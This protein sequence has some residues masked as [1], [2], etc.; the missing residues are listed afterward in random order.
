M[1]QLS[2]YDVIECIYQSD[3]TCVYRALR[4]ADQQPV[5]LKQ[6]REKYPSSLE[7]SRFQHAYQLA[8]QLGLKAVIYAEALITLD[9]QWIMILEDIGG[10]SL[11]EHINKNL[12]SLSENLTLALQLTEAIATL[13]EA[14]VIHKN[15]NSQN[16][17][18][19]RDT[20]IIKLTDLAIASL[21]P[22]EAPSL[23]NSQSLEGTLAYLSPEQTGRINLSLDY[24]TDFYSLGVTLFELFTGQLP[25]N[26]QDPLELIHSHIARQ[27]PN[28]CYVNAQLPSTIGAIIIKLLAK[29]PDHRY[30]STWGLHADL[31]RCQQEWQKQ[32]YINEFKLGKK[33]ISDKFKL[34]NKLYERQWA[35]N[36]IL[37]AIDR[38]Q[39]HERNELILITGYEGIGKTS[40]VKTVFNQVIGLKSGFYISGRFDSFHHSIPYY[41]LIDAVKE[42]VQQ[43]LTLNDQ[44][45]TQL[46]QRLLAALGKNISVILNLVPE[47]TLILGELSDNETAPDL[48]GQEAFNRFQWV[49]IKTLQVFAQAEQPLILFLDDLQLADSASLS[50]LTALLTQ[51]NYLLVITAYRDYEIT[52]PQSLT[53]TLTALRESSITINTI[54]LQPLSKNQVC[55]YIADILHCNPHQVDELA[56]LILNKTYGNPFFIAQFLKSLHAEK[57]ITFDPI[58]RHWEW[59]IERIY[60]Q[61]MT[62]NVVALL[63]QDIQKLDQETQFILQLSACIGYQFELTILADVSQLSIKEIA[64]L[65]AEPISRQLILPLEFNHLSSLDGIHS[66]SLEGSLTHLYRFSHERIQQAAYHLL[67]IHQRREIHQKIG[68]LWLQQTPQPEQSPR[69]FDIVN[70]LNAGELKNYSQDYLDQLARFNLAAGRRA[71]MSAAYESASR[72]LNL[73]LGLLGSQAWQ[74]CYS[75]VLELHIV[76]AETFCLRGDFANTIELTETILKHTDCLLDQVRAYEVKIQMYKAQN[77]LQQAVNLGL[78][79]LAKLGIRFKKNPRKLSQLFEIALTR[80]ALMG[81]PI[82]ELAHLPPMLDLEK[83]AAMRLLLSISPPI[84]AVSPNLLPLITCK[85]VRL[86]IAYGNAPES[87]PAYAS[88]GYLLCEQ[89]QVES[90]YR[91]GQLALKLQAQQPYAIL[92]S[93]VL[94]I[95]YGVIAHYKQSLHDTLLPLKEA[96]Q[97]GLD[98]GNFEYAMVSSSTWMMHAFFAGYELNQLEQEIKS[99]INLQIQLKQH[100][101]L[102]VNRL[103]LQTVSNLLNRENHT[104]EALIHLEGQYYQ[105]K[106]LLIEHEKAGARGLIFQ[107]YLQ[108]LVLSCF[109]HHKGEALNNAAQAET[110][111]N[112]V[113]G[114]VLIPTFYFYD[115]LSQL[116][117]A[118]TLSPKEQKPYLAKVIKNQKKLLPYS[119]QAPMNY[120]HKYTLIRALYAQSAGEYATAREYYDQA[121]QQALAHEFIHEAALAQ[122]LAGQFYLQRQ[123]FRLAQHYLSDAFQ[124]YNRWGAYAKLKQIETH[125]GRFL[126]NCLSFHSVN[127]LDGTLQNSTADLELASVLKAAQVFSSEIVLERLLTKMMLITLE[128]A[129]AQRGFL[130]LNRHG[131]WCV[132]A[133]TDSEQNQVKILP[134]LPLKDYPFLAAGIVYYVARTR[135]TLVLNDAA[136][137]PR[138]ANDPYL[139]EKKPK[140]VLCTPLLNQGK[141]TGLLYLENNL[142]M[143]IFTPNRL[144]LLNLLS[145][146]MAIAIDNARLYAELEEKVLERT[147]ALDIKNQQ[148][149]DLNQE[150]NEFLAIVAHDLKNPLSGI[151]GLVEAIELEFDQLK[152]EEILEM[153]ATVQHSAQQMFELINNLLNVHRIESGNMTFDFKIFNLLP[154]A[155]HLIRT[156]E[157]RANHKSIT[158]RLLANESGYPVY[159]DEK[160]VYQILDNLLSNAIKYSPYHTQVTLY[161]QSQADYLKCVIEDQGQGFTAADKQQLFGKFTRLSAQPTGEESATG[162]GLFIVKK[163]VHLLN[164]TVECESELGKGARFIV[165]LP[166]LSCVQR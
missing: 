92:K 107:V 150:K 61:D 149:M 74:R 33:D 120:Q 158:L 48:T 157:A 121:I 154:L 153:L 130:L 141:L 17:I 9:A 16:I 23:K 49:W 86:S 18:Y 60:A 143:G 125:Y 28:P 134:A 159:A 54:S 87:I 165:L 95:V 20:G 113:I 12:F 13:H 166:S 126:K 122:E 27:A 43:L 100:T 51:V 26:H 140:S 15:I 5:I 6:L 142:A 50:L 37:K 67:P 73:G 45:L 152:K 40:L 147:E 124:H 72:Y 55:Q 31:L 84:Y 103:Y 79:V 39:H 85:R 77:N 160:I 96:Q 58:Q 70:Q 139:L 89:Q 68:E 161:L 135:Q 4:H 63:T 44:Q 52:A 162:L 110:H 78:S 83:Q 24:R 65:L 80:L 164:G 1:L 59:D 93:R 21:L 41:G 47:L 19:N 108:K 34:P 123:L 30:Q 148:L 111:L 101:H 69:L 38:I 98:T 57:L 109:L 88:Y 119:Q 46:R 22:R 2:G 102:H 56:E 64:K 136:N 97:S 75:L 144:T 131:Q 3:K 129:G 11:K 29:S 127:S 99:E 163:L 151:Q 105:E 36:M 81:R 62:D 106:Q 14:N 156:Y 32:R 133:E 146:Q 76:A 66:A 117:T 145:T 116:L 118:L 53:Q 35:I 10:M 7:I 94:Q 25:F 82:D 132:Q 104:C 91:F 8:H 155:H 128:N 71:L 137:N 112:A 90:G 42:L 114:S 138:F 115:S